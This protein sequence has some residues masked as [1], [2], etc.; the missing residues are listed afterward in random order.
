MN[1]T[2]KLT[3]GRFLRYRLEGDTVVWEFDGWDLAVHRPVA[4]MVGYYMSELAD[5]PAKP[6]LAE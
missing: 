1:A 4:I 2:N 6:E 5:P 3:L